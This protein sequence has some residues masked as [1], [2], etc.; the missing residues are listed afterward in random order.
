LLGV[1][2]KLWL[3]ESSKFSLKKCFE[4]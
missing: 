4:T 1:K 3:G 2:S